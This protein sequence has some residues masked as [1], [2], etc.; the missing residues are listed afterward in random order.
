MDDVIVRPQASISAEER[1]RRKAA[2]DY[3]RASVR[4]EGFA[5]S[6]EVE[7]LS[8]RYIEGEITTAEHSA[9]IRR[10]HEACE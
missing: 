10:R 7:E 6:P 3:P 4:L 1:A 9:A 5:V 2:I 8:R